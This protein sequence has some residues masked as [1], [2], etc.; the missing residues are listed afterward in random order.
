MSPAATTCGV[1]SAGCE[2][3]VGDAV[4]VPARGAERVLVG[5]GTTQVEVQVV[6]PRVADAAVDLRAILED[7][8]RRFAGR[9]LRRMARERAVP[10]G[11]V[12][13][14]RAV[15]HGRGRALQR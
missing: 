5:G 4:E 13:R 3:Q 10:G 1:A 8:P 12:A 9:G 14:H 7:A 15:L 6:L 11:A 2:Q